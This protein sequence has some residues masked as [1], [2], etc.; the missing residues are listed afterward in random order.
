MRVGVLAIQGNFQVHEERLAELGAK[1]IQVRKPAELAAISGLVLP[2]GE[3]STMLRLLDQEFQNAIISAIS[4]GLPVLATCAGAILLA[5]RVQNPDQ[6][7]FGLIDIDIRRNAYGRQ[8]D[9]FI[10]TELSWTTEGVQV[11]NRIGSGLSAIAE[12]KVEA[13]FIRAP[14][15]TRIGSGVASLIELDG[16]PVLVQQNNILAATFHPEMSRNAGAVHQLF[17][18]Q[19]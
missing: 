16:E 10:N 18:S 14:R 4:G 2:G 7:S 9:S 12:K 6:Y 1:S 17:L 8:V 5:K 11:L 13:V 3:S 19:L 15:I